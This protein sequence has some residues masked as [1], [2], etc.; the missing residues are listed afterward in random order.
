[1]ANPALNQQLPPVEGA[2]GWFALAPPPDIAELG[3]LLA[4]LRATGHVVRGFIDRAALFAAWFELS[5]PLVV[6]E[7]SRQRLSISVAARDAE[8]AAL[9][10]HVS[11]PG[12]ERA[13]T[14]AWLELA[15]ATLVQ[16]TRFDPL[17]DQRHEAQLR[18]ELPRLAAEAERSGQASLDIEAGTG[19]L[20]LTLTRDQF[21]VAAAPVLQPLAS[22]LQ[23]LSAANGAG[24][25]LVPAAMLDIPGIDAAIASARFARPLRFEEGLAA[26]A[27]RELPIEAAAPA[28]AVPYRTQLPLL[29]GSPPPDALVPLQLRGQQPEVMATH[30]VYRGRALPLTA[31]GLVLGRDPGEA[32]IALPLPDGVAGL[33]RRHCTLRR[34][35]GRSQ[36]I[37]HSS[38][39]SWVD[40]VRVRGRALLP[41]GS[42]LKLGDP[43]VE[44]QLVALGE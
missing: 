22:A 12:G 19:A 20:A 36:I 34:E 2:E 23:A 5:A 11:L 13:L 39:G 33:S 40:G 15:R 37:D 26:R 25:L 35:R 24:A 38:H 31:T 9:H 32:S 8:G 28:G 27:L 3:Q 21:A 16:Q 29:A 30:V 4:Q 14:A 18:A 44:L 1:M 43:G 42:T 17:H 41:A 10:R 7:L 6:L